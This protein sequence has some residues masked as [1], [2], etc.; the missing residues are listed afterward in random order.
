MLNSVFSGGM[1]REQR[2]KSDVSRCSF[3]MPM[4]THMSQNW[5]VV[6]HELS[7]CMQVACHSILPLIQRH[8][9]M[10]IVTDA[11]VSLYTAKDIR[12]H[13]IYIYIY[14]QFKQ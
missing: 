2:T 5:S 3:S 12:L 11:G 1:L 10:Q 4:H 6:M 8:V 13:N 7:A 14:L 9:G